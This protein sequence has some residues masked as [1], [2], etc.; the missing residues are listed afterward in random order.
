[1]AAARRVLVYVF[2]TCLRLLH[3][4]MP[5]VT[6]IL[7]QQLPHLGPSIMVAPWPQDETE[8]Q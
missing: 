6:E 8:E 5:F 3:P 2:D 4:F 1:M 7:W